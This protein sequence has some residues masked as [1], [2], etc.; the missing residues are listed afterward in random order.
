MRPVP[1]ARSCA[2][3]S[4]SCHCSVLPPE[5][6]LPLAIERKRQSIEIDW[7]LPTNGDGHHL[8]SSGLPKVGLFQ[9]GERAPTLDYLRQVV[10]AA[11]QAAFDGIMVPTASGFEDPWLIVALMVQEVRRLQFILTLRPGVELPAY[12][13]YKAATL[14]QLSDNRLALH[15]VSGS[16]RFEQRALGDFLEHDERYA[17]SAEFLDVF[18][19]TWAG[20]EHHGRHYRTGSPAPIA[21]EAILPPICFGGASAVAER[22][23]ASHAQTYLMWGE[24][25]AMI[26]ER[27]Q[28]MRELAAA[29]GRELRFGLRLHVFAAA[30]SRQAWRHV[31]RLL[32]EIPRD[33]IERAQRQLAAYESVGQSRQI[34]LTQGRAQGLRDLEVSPN[35]WAGVGLVRGGAGTA[36][37]GSYA[38][39]AERIEEYRQLGVDTFILSGYPHLEE[40]IHLGEE[41]LPLLRREAAGAGA[42]K[43]R[44]D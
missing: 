2:L 16:S 37:V 20:R 41:L 30:D 17:R 35:L 24:P 25:P 28:R 36:L 34:S 7:F 39:V 4:G 8:T 12:S 3:A 15:L 31:G 11:E 5:R 42:R 6:T 38:E 18:R 14:Q 29:A 26:H 27:I 19:A 44:R 21:D 1:C 32:E 43:R 13:A 9:Q 22:I 40:A 10:R 33:A 23:A